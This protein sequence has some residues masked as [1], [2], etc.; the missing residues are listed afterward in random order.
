LWAGFLA[1][2]VAGPWFF[3]G[4]LFGTDWPGPRHFLFPTNL[5]SA[6]P[7][8]AALAAAAS[9]VGAEMTGKLFV[10][11]VLL[12]SGALAY[13]AVPTGGFV[14][15]AVAATIYVVNPFVYGRLHYGQFFL[16]GGYAALPWVASR[17][18]R[19]L[20]GPG[21]VTSLLA[22]LGLVVLGA[23]STHVFLMAWVFAAALVCAQLVLARGKFEH[24]MRFGPWLTL[25][26]VV[27]VLGSGY[28]LVPSLSGHGP[29]ASLIAGTTAA[30]LGAYAA[31]PDHRLG[32]VPNLL[33]L[34][35]F[36]AEN[37]GRFTS[38]KAFVP[39]WPALLVVL[40][41]LA[42]VGAAAT[43]RGWRT[44]LAAWV[45]GLVLA[46]AVAIVLEMG[47]SNPAT[48]GLVQWLD[49][50]LAPYRGMR[51][52]GKWAVVLAVVY[53]QLGALGAAA[54]F[55]RITR[56]RP[57]STRSE[58]VAG[59]LV[60]ALLSLPLYYGNG[61]LFGAHGEI[62]S[63]QYPAG[64]YAADRVLAA[65]SSPDRTLFLPWHEYMRYSFIQNQNAV[66]VSPAPTFFSV[67][68]IVSAN[69]EVPGITAP[70]TADQAAVS[71]LVLAGDKDL[72]AEALAARG[73]KYVLLAHELDWG[74]YQ[75]LD[76]QPGLVKVGD[77]GSISLYR[78][79]LVS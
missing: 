60:A 61:L 15:R 29:E 13:L 49:T 17:L 24:L 26:F 70:N 12:G 53:S 19:L 8:E 7:I 33:G 25:T 77:Y 71:N 27:T 54:V 48:V 47:V 52:A 78:N 72:W 65:D 67:P 40:L 18:R 45:A 31:V 39:F 9:L 34:Y 14:A 68:I 23:F 66:V 41:L 11:G 64:W 76:N 44:P 46:G 42:G 38:M 3:P 55:E 6:A 62:K 51:D 69:P 30:E 5:S 35:G 10:M 74:S 36:W 37:S 50:H 28:W 22:A 58:W 43:L 2:A 57:G 56:W 63:S 20:C 1:I 75:Y 32:L 79:T 21:L 16:L 4:Y 73:I 59:I